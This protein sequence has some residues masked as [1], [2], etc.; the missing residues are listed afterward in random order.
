M[1]KKEKTNSNASTTKL[2]NTNKQNNFNNN[3]NV[4]D[5]ARGALNVTKA[6]LGMGAKLVEGDF[7]KSSYSKGN[8]Y[9]RKRNYQSTEYISKVENN[10]EIEKLGDEN[11]PKK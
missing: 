6:Y 1:G 10:N 5:V 11:E 9:A 4:G 3:V 7:S 8:Y 2:N